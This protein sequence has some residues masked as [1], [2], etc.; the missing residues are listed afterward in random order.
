M[1]KE[2]EPVPNWDEIKKTRAAVT[3]GEFLTIMGWSS[4]R[5]HRHRSKIRVVE[6]FGC[7][8]IAGSEVSRI[9]GESEEPKTAA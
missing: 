9:L 7:R 8:M 3:V 6:G 1:S 2:K 4:S 5:L